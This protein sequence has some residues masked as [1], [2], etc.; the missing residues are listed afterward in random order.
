MKKKKTP[1][2]GRENLVQSCFVSCNLVVF[3]FCLI[4]R[5]VA[6]LLESHLQMLL[7]SNGGGIFLPL[8]ER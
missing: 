6:L 8:H 5:R 4:I 1:Q 7:I 2:H 3:V